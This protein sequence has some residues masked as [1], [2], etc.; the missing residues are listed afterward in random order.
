MSFA[1]NVAPSSRYSSGRT[2]MQ[3]SCMCSRQGLASR[4]SSGSRRGLAISREVRVHDDEDR[5]GSTAPAIPLRPA[6]ALTEA[7]MEGCGEGN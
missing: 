6:I 2:M 3:A 5:G 7:K 1:A 4:A